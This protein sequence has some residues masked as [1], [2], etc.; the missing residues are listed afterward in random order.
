V[1]LLTADEIYKYAFYTEANNLVIRGH[2]VYAD[3][4]GNLAY[5]RDDGIFQ[6]LSLC[7]PELAAK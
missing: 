3:K 7:V 1:R 6:I 2:K 5:K 4:R